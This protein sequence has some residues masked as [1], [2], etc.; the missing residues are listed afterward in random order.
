MSWDVAATGIMTT[1]TTPKGASEAI[2]IGWHHVY[3]DGYF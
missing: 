1:D 2:R 3:H